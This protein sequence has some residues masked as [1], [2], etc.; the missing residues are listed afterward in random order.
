MKLWSDRRL[1][2]SLTRLGLEFLL[3]LLVV[4]ALA[5]RT[6]NN[7]L[8]LIFSLM[9]GLFLVSG[10]VSMRALGGL[11]L[12]RIE[13]GRLFARMGGD[14]RIRVRD[15]APRRLRGLRVRLWAEGGVVGEGHYPGGQGRD[16]EEITLG[17]RP[18][19]RGPWRLESLLFVTR[20]PFGFLEKSWRVPL[21]SEVLVLPYPRRWPQGE[22]GRGEELRPASRPGATSPEGAR[23]FREGD[24]PSRIHW[25]RTAQRGEPWVRDFEGE[26]SRG[27]RLRL[28]LS[29]WGP[30]R[31]FEE[32]LE[33]L[34]GAILMARLRHEEVCLE[35]LGTRERRS[36]QGR[37]ACWRALARVRA[38]LRVSSSQ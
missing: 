1:G 18:G 2:L 28:D 20:F 32:E 10:W 33:C 34:S 36:F 21:G 3:A 8:Y 6:A 9:A 12:L 37:M 17:V 5:V 15:R 35:V 4:G 13:E 27:L 24:A 11:E 38:G 14:L 25:K 22:E 19:R 23:P 31:A 7:L 16:E 26:R 30:G 29:Q